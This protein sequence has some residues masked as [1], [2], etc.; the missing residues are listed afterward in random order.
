MMSSHREVSLTFEKRAAPRCRGAVLR[1]LRALRGR[2]LLV[3]VHVGLVRSLDWNPKV[4][5]LLRSKLS[6]L[7]SE[8]RQMQPSDLFIE[9]LRQ[10]VDALLVSR[11]VL[12]QLDLRHHLIGEAR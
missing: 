3:P 5:S 1:A 9:P 8:L 11:G 6:K 7:H 2:F 4:L 12:V 10:R